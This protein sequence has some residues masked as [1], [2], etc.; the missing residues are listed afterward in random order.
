MIAV[1][2][3]SYIAILALFVWLK[4]IPFNMFWKISPVVVLLALLFGLFIPMG[5]A[6]R[7]GRSP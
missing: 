3:N 1:L 2:L 6:R 7:R 4:V 5:G